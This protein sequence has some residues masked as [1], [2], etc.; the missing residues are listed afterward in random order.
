LIREAFLAVRFSL[1]LES[2]Q[3]DAAGAELVYEHWHHPIPRI[4]PPDTLIVDPEGKLLARF[5]SDIPAAEALEIL[6]GV[7]DAHP[8]LAAVSSRPARS[9]AEV[10]RDVARGRL[11]LE[12]VKVRFEEGERRELVRPLELWLSEH[13][14]R[15]PDEAAEARLLLGVVRYHA[16]DFAGADAAWAE[17]IER[18]PNHPLRHRAFYF[19]IDWSTW[20]GPIH[21]LLLG[22]RHPGAADWPPEAPDPERRAANLAAV[23]EIP[24]YVERLWGSPMVYVP[25]G[26]FLMGGSPARFERELPVREV[27]LSRPFLMSAWPVTRRIWHRFDPEA[28]PGAE[29]LGLA[30]DLPATGIPLERARDFCSFLSSKTKR[31]VRLPTEA[32]WEYAARGGIESAPYPWGHEEITPERCNYN[33]PRA[34]PVACYAPNGYGLFDMVGNVHEW[35]ADLYA[36]DAYSQTPRE[37]TDPK[38]PESVEYPLRVVRGGVPGMD[39]CRI[40]CRN[41]WRLGAIEQRQTIGIRLVADILEN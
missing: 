34:V 8:E 6:Q 33:L 21:P 14:E 28:F 13:G 40:F 15:C 11:A 29:S 18:H 9:V 31:V 24:L 17:L 32:E 1:V 37:C 38:G 23:D 5:D 26:T 7:L 20:K 30:G 3:F 16:E 2:L 35:T 19:R 12:R 10:P 39:A 25:A 4:Y 22:S 27:T 41:S 36:E